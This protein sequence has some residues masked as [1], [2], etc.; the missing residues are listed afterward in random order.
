MD[1]L[2]LIA[3]KFTK[4]LQSSIFDTK[5]SHLSS[6]KN[7]R[8]SLKMASLTNGNGKPYKIDEEKDSTLY[9][10]QDCVFA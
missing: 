1:S 7:D 9:Y 6:Y 3:L 4:D 2:Y 8:N 10:A 5:I